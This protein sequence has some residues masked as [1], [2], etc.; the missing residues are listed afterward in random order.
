MNKKA[1]FAMEYMLL[2]GL[3]LV[4]LIPIL[5]YSMQN[6][7]YETTSSQATESVN[8]LAKTADTVYSLGPGNKKFVQIA[9]PSGKMAIGQNEILLKLEIMGG[10]SDVFQTASAKLVAGKIGGQQ[11]SSDLQNPTDINGGIYNV[12][13]EMKNSSVLIG[14]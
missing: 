14:E 7:N 13:I 10:A 9:I 6:L 2:I 11:I 1:Q 8:A 3:L 5:Y 12:K 4:V